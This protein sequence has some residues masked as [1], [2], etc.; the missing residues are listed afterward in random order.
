[1]KLFRNI[2]IRNKIT[3]I[4]LLT[5]VIVLL[6]LLISFTILEFSISRTA[7]VENVATLAEV[8]GT[9]STAA[10]T[11]NDQ[12]S[13]E[14]T[15]SALSAESEIVSAAIYT[16]DGHLFALY[17]HPLKRNDNLLPEAGPDAAIPARQPPVSGRTSRTNYTFHASYLELSQRIVLEGEVIGSI[18]L[19]STLADLYRRLGWY[20]IFALS[21]IF[22]SLLIAYLLSSRLQRII[23]RPIIDLAQTMKMVSR[24]KDYSVQ[25]E[26]FS[27]DELGGLIDGFNEMLAQIQKRD[28][29]LERHREELEKEVQRRTAEL[30]QSN[31]ELERTIEE[32]NRA[33]DFLA[34]NERR[35]AYAQQAARLGYWEWLIG[36]DKLVWS[37]E[38]FRLFGLEPEEIDMNR[39]TF[40]ALI[41]PNDKALVGDAMVASLSTG[42][43]FRVDSHIITAAGSQCIVNIHGEVT[44]NEAGEPVKMTG[45]IQDIT[46]RKEAEQALSESEEKY[47]ALMDNA[48]EGI[49]LADLD[50][51]HLEANKKMVDLLGYPL[52][53]LL[54]LNPMQLIFPEG[55]DRV[56]KAFKDLIA[57]GSGAV[58]NAL[59]LRK[60]G[61]RVPVDITTSLVR[62][63]GK[64]VIQGIFRDVSERRKMEEERLLLSKL[65]SLGLLAGGIAH[66]FNNILTAILGNISLARLDAGRGGQLE[67]PALDRL[68]EAEKACQRAQALA[69]QLLSFAK[70]NLPIR[71]ATSAANLVKESINLALSG[72]KASSNLVLPEDLWSMEVDESQI[73]QVFNNLL[74]NADQAMPAGGIITVRAENV[75]VGDEL[76]LPGGRYVKITISDQG[77]GIPPNYLGKIFD[78]YFTTKQKGSGLGLAT[79]HSIIRNNAG[80]I[81][82]ESQVGSGTTFYVYLPAI[83]GESAPVKGADIAP[84]LGQGRILVMDDEKM[85]REVMG[86]MLKKLGYQGDFAVNGEEAVELYTSSLQGDQPFSAVIFDLTVPGGMGGKEA[87]RQI[88]ERDT[89]VKA[90]VSSGYSDDPIMANFKEYGFKGVITK[91]YRITKLSEVLHDV[92]VK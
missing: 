31:S 22:P 78:P 60:D 72:S 14:A 81:T 92:I 44:A 3:V 37:G 89:E 41:H 67:A 29:A 28:H 11:F 73:S 9:N 62:Y 12:K 43:P 5:C 30:S 58:N 76:P 36:P 39:Q 86:A 33:T 27:E 52:E 74:I 45:T 54:S 87:L 32:L 15:L 48:G 38:V 59:V 24:E 56:Q 68:E 40:L 57:D 84:I 7:L 42:Q 25:V 80:Y 6:S 51:N 4:T 64:T 71:K 17:L 66:D 53:E 50:G 19:K 70:G 35:L 26:K 47:R 34:Q 85:V 46:E 2:S 65:E 69:G 10:L 77:I 21:T 88:L 20:V 55:K 8:L 61:R 13:A 18:Y 90:I 63:A 91:P 83:E 16:K 49:L 1:V 75:M 23:S 79:V 82:V